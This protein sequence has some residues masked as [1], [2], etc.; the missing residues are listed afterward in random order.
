MFTFKIIQQTNQKKDT[1][2]D[3]D[4][5]DEGMAKSYICSCT[6]TIIWLC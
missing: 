3:G 6:A 5:D 2:G 1:I 4:G